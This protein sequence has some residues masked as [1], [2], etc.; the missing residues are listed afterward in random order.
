MGQFSLRIFCVA[1]LRMYTCVIWRGY[2]QYVPTARMAQNGEQSEA[3]MFEYTEKLVGHEYVI[4][5]VSRCIIR[6]GA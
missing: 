2:S 5:S 3:E 1:N 6:H 4:W